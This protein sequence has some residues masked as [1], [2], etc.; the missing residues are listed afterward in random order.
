VL[1]SA[2]VGV[3]AAARGVSLIVTGIRERANQFDEEGGRTI[4]RA[5]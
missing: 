4:G 3:A 5:A 2:V 1:V